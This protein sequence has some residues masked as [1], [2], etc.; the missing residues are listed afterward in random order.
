MIGET[1]TRDDILQPSLLYAESR[2]GARTHAYIVRCIFQS[3]ERDLLLA[4]RVM[5]FQD[6]AS[7]L[8]LLRVNVPN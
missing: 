4:E 1:S 5:H 3:K 2:A 7:Q 8:P 6:D